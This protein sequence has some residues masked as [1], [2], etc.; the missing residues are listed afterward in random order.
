MHCG[1]CSTRCATAAMVA[2]FDG[3][4]PVRQATHAANDRHPVIPISEW[5]ISATGSTMRP[6]ITLR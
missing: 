6:S 3:E 1:N 2:A 5:S 4:Q